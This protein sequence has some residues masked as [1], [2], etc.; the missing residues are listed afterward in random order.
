[1]VAAAPQSSAAWQE[2][3]D[4]TLLSSFDRMLWGDGGYEVDGGC[5][6]G[7]SGR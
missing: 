3:D 2:N 4:I 6:G 5:T 7:G 1:M